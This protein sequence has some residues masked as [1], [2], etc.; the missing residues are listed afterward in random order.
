MAV[1]YGRRRIGKSTLIAE[2]IK[3]KR[4]IYYMAT[5]VGTARNTELLAKETL[6]ILAPA[7][8]NISFGTIEDLL[9]FI[10]ESASDEKI[11]FVIDEFPYWAEKDDSIL[12]ILQKFA[13]KEWAE[14]NILFILCGSALSFMEDKVL[15]E[16]SPLFG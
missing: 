4:A 1:I 16:K 9:S 3:D 15:S 10:G 12:S 5:K 13:D 7:L 2:F 14:K 8:K 11:V 6:R